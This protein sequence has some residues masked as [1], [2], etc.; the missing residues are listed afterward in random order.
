MKIG[1]WKLDISINFES[2][3]TWSQRSSNS[4]IPLPSREERISP[5]S[6]NKEKSTSRTLGLGVRNYFVARCFSERWLDWEALKTARWSV[7]LRSQDMLWYTPASGL[8][9]V[10]MASCLPE[11]W[12]IC[13]VRGHTRLIILPHSGLRRWWCLIFIE[14]IVFWFSNILQADLLK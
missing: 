10:E 8:E 5:I 11:R 1:I 14:S 2:A 13:A 12:N 7:A 9:L 6:T 4:G 3:Y